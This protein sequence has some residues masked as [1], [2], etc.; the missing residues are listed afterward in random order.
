MRP[1]QLA[2]SLL[3]TLTVACGVAAPPAVAE[4]KRPAARPEDAKPL[5]KA[6]LNDNAALASA[7]REHYT[8]YEYRVPMRD[9]VHL[10]TSVYVPKDRSRSYPILLTRTPYSVAPYGID[11][12]PTA[13]EARSLRSLAPSPQFVREGYILVR[14]DVRGRMMSEGTFVDVRPIAQKKGEIDESTDAYDTIDWLVHNI[15]GN[16]GRVGTWGISYPG[17]Y[18]AQAAINAHPALKAVSPQAPVTEWFLGDDF[19]H[20]GAFFLSAAFDF[21]ANFGKPR[22][23]PTTKAT[24]DFEHDTADAYDF[25]LA[26]G[27]LSNANSRYLKGEIA[28]WNDLMDHGTR[29]AFWKA[30]DPRPHY[31]EIRPAVLTVGGWFDAED[32]FGALETY[33]AIEKQGARGENT[34]VMGPWAHGGWARSSG[35]HLGDVTFGAKTSD[36]Y[37]EQILFPFFQRHLKARAGSAAPE[38]WVFETGTNLWQNYPSWPPPGA[39]RQELF[40]HAGGKLD[41]STPAKEDDAGFDAYLSDP[42]KPVPYRAKLSSSTDEDYMTED[43]RFA[44]RRPDVLVYASEPL[45]GDVTLAGPIEASLWVSTTGTD[46]DFVVKLIDVYPEDYADP[47][48]NPSS[49]KMGGYQQLVR[50]EVMRGKFRTSFETPEPFKPGEPTRVRFS[51]PD[52]NH[53]FRTG[54]KLMVQVQSSWFPLVDRNPQ[55]FTDIYHAKASDFRAATHRVYREA[56]KASGLLVTVATG[57]LPVRTESR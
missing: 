44:A 56:D 22:P 29:D 26:L 31:K 32:L 20:N 1:Y 21:Y 52:C 34:L 4:P 40:F 18:A 57:K 5:I 54:H 2:L 48:P 11:K 17:F 51:V 27:P 10:F 50:A 14:Q 13:K 25:F 30:S 46:A 35:D 37:R 43:Q 47:E 36:F 24:W 39:K 38:A 42:Q 23:A 28:F 49:V 19:H 15:P 7:L 33:R 53:T 3:C 8:K 41:A 16:N 9:G 45:S 55:T 6:E 12:V